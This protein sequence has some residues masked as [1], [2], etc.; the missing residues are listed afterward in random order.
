MLID[1]RK[2]SSVTQTDLAQR[3]ARPQSFISKFESG[4]RRLDVVEF[5]EVA[6]ALGIDPV[7]VL[8]AVMRA[9]AGNRDA[10]ALRGEGRARQQG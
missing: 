9:C 7:R 8:K 6:K 4:E 3:L 5:I 1:A 10:S 2:R